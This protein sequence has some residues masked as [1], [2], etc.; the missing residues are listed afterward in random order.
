MQ[1]FLDLVNKYGP[2]ICVLVVS[3]Y[4]DQMLA[5]RHKKAVAE[6]ES[7]MAQ[8]KADIEAKFAGKSPADIINEISMGPKS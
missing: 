5:E 4:R 3:F 2:A 8:N 7:K 6:L 1:E